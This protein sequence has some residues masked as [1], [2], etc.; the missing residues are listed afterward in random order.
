MTLQQNHKISDRWRYLAVFICLIIAF[1]VLIVWNIN[2]GAVDISFTEIMK[3]IFTKKGDQT[4]VNI[5]WQIRL[6]RIITAAI[7]GGGLAVSGFLM[8]TFFNNPIAGPYVLGISSGS[9]LFVA[10]AMI[11]A[12]KYVHHTNSWMIVIAAFAGE[13]RF[14]NERLRVYFG[15]R[16]F[17]CR[18]IGFYQA[19]CSQ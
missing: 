10:V 11:V 19:A 14:L 8:Q 7:L 9:K 13:L 18:R 2:S 1:F 17:C 12:L 6:P 16:L 15:E 4:N 3:I 5:I